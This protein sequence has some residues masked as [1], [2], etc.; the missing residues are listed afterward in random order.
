MLMEVSVEAEGVGLTATPASLVRGL[1]Q[2]IRRRLTP[3]RPERSAIA[4]ALVAAV[5][6]LLPP[7][8]GAKAFL[9][10]SEAL[11]LAFPNCAI[12][13]TTLYLTSEQRDRAKDLSGLDLETSLA[14]AYR[15]NCDGK[16]AGTAYFDTHR[17]R[18]L[19]ETIMVVVAP[20]ASVTRVEL[21]SFAEPRDYIPHHKW[22]RQFD[23][24]ALSEELNLKRGIK[25]VTGATLTARATT[26]ATRRVLALHD[27]LARKRGQAR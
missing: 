16:T 15:S 21:L 18:T 12:E 27:Y 26:S 7:F 14:H 19:R 24:K 3:T 5:C 4:S 23:G 11:A 2:G 10:Q 25:P 8:A 17:V 6:L 22:Y 9:S 13:R 1:T 20:D